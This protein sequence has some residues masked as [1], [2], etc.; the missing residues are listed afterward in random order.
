MS[1]S[2]KMSLCFTVLL[3]HMFFA[4]NS[5]PAQIAEQI[6]E[7]ALAATVYLEMK[8]SSGTVLGFGSGFFVKPNLI[9]TNYHVIEGAASG[10]AK[11]IGKYTK[12]TIE[13]VTATDKTND[14]ALLK[15]TASGI[16]PLPL[17]DSGVVKI[18]AK[19]YV[20]GNSKG[21]EGT[22][23]DGIISSRR[24]RYTK[25]RLQMT[26]PISPESNGG[27]VLNLRGQVIGVSF[28]NVDGGENL[29]LTIPS[30]YVKALLAKSKPSIP[31]SQRDKSISAKTY[32]TWGYLKH[33]LRDYNG[34]ISSYTHAIRLNPNYAEAY[35]GRGYVKG[36]LGQYNTE[37]AD[38]NIAIRLK[39]DF[40][41]AYVAR[42]Y[43]KGKLGQDFA[44]ISDY[45]NA[46][47]IKPN[48]VQA[49]LNRGA[50][51]NRLGQYNSAIADFDTAIRLKSDF[52]EA[53][54]SRG[55]AKGSLGQFNAE[56]ADY[57]IAIRLKPNFVEAYLNR[58]YVKNRLG[59]FTSAITDFDIVI[60]LKP[61]FAD[62]YYYRGI[63]KGELKQY[64]EAIAD[65]DT[66][67]RLKP[68]SAQAYYNR[69]LTKSRLGQ[70]SKGKQDILT[71]LKLAEQ[72]GDVRLK[73]H[74]KLFLQKIR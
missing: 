70:I 43:A 24:D 28:M 4:I 44:A 51:K 38:Y 50:A 69:G 54:Y 2:K 1:F 17:G 8:D 13:G 49:Y 6:A 15:V 41:E 67:I 34:A 63:V 14:L 58:G 52:A 22:F 60:Q 11:L 18:G 36:S 31:L 71:A 5:S 59:Q 3:L 32:F 64:K 68:D 39:P 20:A 35:Y 73:A 48:L 30:K 27:P 10:T 56:I 53:Y 16:K 65:F 45:D 7:K 55:H 57:D 26:A 72:S 74:I 23:S 12:Y 46:I 62:V 21:L 61:N 9:V 33:E 47:R 66:T 37:I 29:N 42:G 40:A 19:V 25:E